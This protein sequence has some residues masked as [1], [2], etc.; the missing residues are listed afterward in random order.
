MD[1]HEAQTA[2]GSRRGQ[3]PSAGD[4]ALRL[5]QLALALLVVQR[6]AYHLSYLLGSP[7]ALA[8]FSDGQLYEVAARDLL[9][10]PPLGSQPFYL[11]GLYAAVLALPMSF[12]GTV[13]SGLLLQLAIAA[14]ALWLFHRAA[15]QALPPLAATLSTVAL[16]SFFE[17][18][19]YENKYLSVSLGVSMNVLALWSLVRAMPSLRAGA[20]LLAGLCGGLSLLGRPNMILALPFSLLAL[21]VLARQAR[22]SAR[23][24]LLLFAL[25]VLLAVAPMALRNQV[26]VGDP[27]VFPSHGGGIPFFIGNN[28]HANGRWNTA[29]GLVTGQVFRERVE[30]ARKLGVDPAGRSAG[31]LDRAIGDALR[32]RGMR[33]IAEHPG[34]WL[35]LTA[36]KLWLT[37]GNHPFVRDYDMRGEREMLGAWHHLGMPFGL[38][39]GLGVIGAAAVAG[40]AARERPE[41]ARMAALLLILGGQFAAVLAANLLVFTSAQN[42]L[43]LSIP[44]AFVAGP[45]MLAIAARVR[46]T[47]RPAFRASLP[48]MALAAL[49]TAQAFWPRTRDVNRPSSVHYYNLAA[50]EEALGRVDDAV[51]HYRIAL[52]RQPD[53]PVFRRSYERALREQRRRHSGR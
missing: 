41:R 43:P 3:S 36:K 27:Q 26:V 39:L 32:A 14:A 25:G 17:L 22:R 1:A 31:Q 15:R 11:Q 47:P 19:Y 4:R 46:S 5:A 34:Q 23:G 42:R 9:V 37:L 29:G 12:T 45:G 49:L 2:S 7:F 10:H 35:A 50:V 8:T 40:R 30:L 33:Y 21:A 13:V 51:E 38:L 18:A 20:L 44:L 28:P 6:V 16:L 48:A 52:Q 53:Q 24:P